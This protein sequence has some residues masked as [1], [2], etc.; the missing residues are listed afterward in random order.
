MK[1]FTSHIAEA[2]GVKEK[3]WANKSG[4]LVMTRIR[5]PYYPYHLQMVVMKPR[6]FGT[7]EEQIKNYVKDHWDV[8]AHGSPKDKDKN[9]DILWDKALAGKI[10]REVT[11]EEFVMRKGWSRVVIDGG[12]SSI[13][14]VH[15]TERQMH[16]I[17]KSIDKNYGSSVLFPE[18]SAFFELTG[19]EFS[20]VIYNKLDWDYYI[21]TGKYT[22]PKRS[23]IGRTMAQF[24]EEEMKSFN[25]YITEVF[26]KPHKWRGGHV[27]KGSITADS[28]RGASEDYIFKASDGGVITVTAS[29]FWVSKE[30]GGG[31]E[32]MKVKKE[33]HTIGIE[34]VKKGKPR[35]YTAMSGDTITAPGRNT[36]DMT[37]D[38]DA[39]RIMATVLDIIAAIIKKHKPMTLH[40]SAD[41]AED[42][43]R[44]AQ[45]VQAK[46][47][48]AG[49]Y[50]A[51]VKR[52]A[53]K[54]GYIS[55]TDDDGERKKWQLT[56]K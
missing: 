29:H 48:R 39:M 32:G 9:L 50:G 5:P 17:A 40:F 44:G 31:H 15:I 20:E 14:N 38:G 33:G 25:Q 42:K 47:G 18:S 4:K 12:S 41:K 34:F 1:S 45:M 11:I 3:G 51:I 22:A 53:S 49:A 24:R 10:D 26:D 2:T 55:T 52:F 43:L 23:E 46:T 16:K 21:K 35:K 54:A 27:A 19:K 8:R 6:V 37:G 30:F 7:T 56:K 36:Y 13:E 28:D